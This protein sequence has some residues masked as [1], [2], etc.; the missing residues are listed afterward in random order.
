MRCYA[1][2]MFH[3]NTVPSEP[4]PKPRVRFSCDFC[5]MRWK[6]IFLHYYLTIHLFDISYR[7]I[8][9][10]RLIKNAFSSERL[11]LLTSF[12][13][14]CN[15]RIQKFPCPLRTFDES[16]DAFFF[17]YRFGYVHFNLNDRMNFQF[18]NFFFP[19]LVLN[20]ITSDGH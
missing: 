1:V 12:N 5:N 9:H 2:R 18:F 15:G 6:T 19:T 7:R 16:F 20:Y 17:F 8:N 13:P 11:L 4:T 10:H 3:I 14:I